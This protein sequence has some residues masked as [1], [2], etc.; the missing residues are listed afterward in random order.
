VPIL[1]TQIS[2]ENS[3]TVSGNVDV[4]IYDEWAN[5]KVSKGG[6]AQAGSL[7]LQVHDVTD[8][9]LP[10]GL[11]YKAFVLDNA[12]GQVNRGTAPAVVARSCG[13]KEMATAY[14]LPATATLVGCT[15]AFQP[16]M[17]VHTMSAA[18]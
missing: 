11:Y 17:S 13:V 8:T 9:L 5:R 18:V 3:T 10:P 16:A 14:P 2:H 15:T 4:G 6:V 1:V 7:A 12:T